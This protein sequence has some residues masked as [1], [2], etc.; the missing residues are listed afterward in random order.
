MLKFALKLDGV[1]SFTLG[2]LT[3]LIRP[4]VGMPVGW[5]IGLGT[6]C[7][8]YGVGVFF[9]GTRATPD[10]R[11]VLLVIIGNLVWGL[12]SILTAELAWFPLTDSG[13]ALVLAQGLAVIGFAVLQY[14][15]LKRAG[16]ASD[17]GTQPR[18]RSLA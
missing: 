16:S 4:E 5:Q 12:D 6:F 11:I 1:A 3:L 8:V 14:V 2:L 18:S 7:V 13:V 10:R 15:G 9:L 17:H